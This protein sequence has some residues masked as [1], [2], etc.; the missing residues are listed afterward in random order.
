MMASQYNP[1]RCVHETHGNGTWKVA[2]DAVD[3]RIANVSFD[4]EYDDIEFDLELAA[5]PSEL[6]VSRLT[7]R[8]PSLST[9]GSGS[10]STGF[11]LGDVEPS[12]ESD[13]YDDDY[14]DDDV[15]AG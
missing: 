3:H 15:S 9:D 7:P 10:H 8:P 13:D 4:D 5:I 1:Q 14:D 12:L 11:V 6:F 2:G